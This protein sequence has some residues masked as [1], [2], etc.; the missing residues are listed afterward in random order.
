MEY[1][2]LVLYGDSLIE[3]SL[4]KINKLNFV[5]K[6]SSTEMPHF[7]KRSTKGPHF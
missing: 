6:I 1:S 5:K 4:T 3:F 7:Q 2:E